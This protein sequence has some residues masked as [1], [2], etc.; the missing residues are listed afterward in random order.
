MRLQLVRHKNHVKTFKFSDFH[1]NV[2]FW[3]SMIV[4]CRQPKLETDSSLHTA[5]VTSTFEFEPSFKTSWWDFLFCWWDWIAMSIWRWLTAFLFSHRYRNVDAAEKIVLRSL[6]C[7]LTNLLEKSS[8]S[9]NASYFIQARN[10][11]HD[12]AF[13]VV[14]PDKIYKFPLKDHGICIRTTYQMSRC[15]C[16][17]LM[18]STSLKG[19]D[20]I[21]LLNLIQMHYLQFEFLVPFRAKRMRFDWT[22]FDDFR[23]H[24][25]HWITV[26]TFSLEAQTKAAVFA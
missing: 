1:E 22:S 2:V 7:W 9:P 6:P 10:S 3:L 17:L 24:R 18:S 12:T 14:I 11:I 15:N 26:L 19:E 21:K 16:S 5:A 8:K 25:S 13:V 20:L 4:S 23:W